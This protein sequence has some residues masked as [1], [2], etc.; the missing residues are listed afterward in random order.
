MKIKIIGDG[1]LANTQVLN[2]ETGER[3]ENVYFVSWKLDGRD[4]CS[5]V[6]LVIRNVPIDVSGELKETI[7]R[8]PSLAW[9]ILAQ[10]QVLVL[11]VEKCH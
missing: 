8:F 2:A 1:S 10:I 7:V 11:Q 5:I 6:N 3:L 9:F 4:G